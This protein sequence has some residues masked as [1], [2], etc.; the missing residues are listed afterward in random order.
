MSSIS[1]LSD[2]C[3]CDSSWISQLS[4][5][6]LP[7]GPRPQ[8]KNHDELCTVTRLVLH[9]YPLHSLHPRILSRLGLRG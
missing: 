9:P 1:K 7:A 4:C 5:Q 6:Q 8:V 2:H 3:V